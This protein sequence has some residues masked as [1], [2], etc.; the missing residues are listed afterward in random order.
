MIRSQFG[1]GLLQLVQASPVIPHRLA[2]PSL[3]Q[4]ITAGPQ[5]WF[6]P[7][8][9]PGFPGFLLEFE[10]PEPIQLGIATGQGAPG[11]LC[12]QIHLSGGALLQPQLPLTQLHRGPPAV[13]A[14]GMV[15]QQF[16]PGG[17][18][19][20]VLAELVLAEAFPEA[21]AGRQHWR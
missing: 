6:A 9:A 20:L 17:G 5:L 12:R 7:A 18:G 16:S 3:Q 11:R 15:Q 13:V 10:A 8:R 2:Q 4:Q 19:P 1:A 21:V 14:A